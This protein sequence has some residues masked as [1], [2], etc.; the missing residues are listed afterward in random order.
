[1]LKKLIKMENTEFNPVQSLNLIHSM[2]NT[3]K[4]K[5]ADDGFFIILWGWLVFIA[6]LTNYIAWLVN[7]EEGA[8]IWA[9]LMP[10]GGIFSFFYGRKRNKKDTVKTYIESYLMYVWLAFGAGLALTLLFM[11]YH[12]IKITYFFLMVLYGIATVTSG[13]LLSFRPLIIGG[14]VSF[15]I[16]ALSTFLPE[17]EQLLCIALSILSSYIIPGHLLKAKYQ[18]QENV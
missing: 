6:A 4:N 16:A 13:G 2:I 7:F 15:V 3:A 12:G 8:L 9:I 11:P 10:L 5:L 18:S 1:L 14:V 17:R